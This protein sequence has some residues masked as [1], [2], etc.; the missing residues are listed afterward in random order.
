VIWRGG[1]SSAG[2]RAILSHTG[3]LASS[4][5][6]WDAM[7]KQAGAIGTKSIDETLDIVMAMEHT[8]HPTGRGPALI[9]MTGGQSVA[10]ADQFQ[11]AGFDVP[12]LSDKSYAELAEFFMTVGGSYR[13]PFDAASTIGRETD[14]LRRILEILA[15]DAAIDGGVGIEM[16]VGRGPGGAGDPMERLNGQLDLLDEYRQRSRPVVLMMMTALG[17]EH[18]AVRARITPAHEGCGTPASTAGSPSRVCWTLRA[19]AAVNVAGGGGEA[20]LGE[21]RE[22]VRSP[23]VPP[24]RTPRSGDAEHHQALDVA[25]IGLDA[26]W[27]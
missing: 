10:I 9:A 21:L 16:G 20:C 14:N 15:D 24:S 12:G 27:V 6:V 22:I 3:S 8:R 26:R 18:R 25:P 13:N 11:N 2:A 5:A 7:V 4:V 17:R 19:R 1:R 23:S